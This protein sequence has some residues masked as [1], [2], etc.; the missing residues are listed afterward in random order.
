MVKPTIT[1]ILWV[2]EDTILASGIGDLVLQK[3]IYLFLS[4]TIVL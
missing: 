2:G 1:W 3:T 4:F